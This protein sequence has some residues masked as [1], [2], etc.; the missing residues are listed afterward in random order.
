MLPRLAIGIRRV[1]RAKSHAGDTCSFG[2]GRPI[3]EASLLLRK[4]YVNG[5]EEGEKGGSKGKD[6]HKDE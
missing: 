1:T 3:S 6:T 2:R 4:S 5:R